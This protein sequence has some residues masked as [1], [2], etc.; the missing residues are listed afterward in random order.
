MKLLNFAIA[1]I[2]DANTGNGINRQFVNQ[3]GSNK[4]DYVRHGREIRANS[5]LALFG[6]IKTSIKQYIEDSKAA[7]QAREN[8]REILQMN[9]HLMKD[10][11]LNYNDG[12]DLRLGLISLDSLNARRDQNRNQQ[13]A[14]L[15]RLSQQ[16]VSVGKYDLESSNEEAYELAKCA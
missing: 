13:D 8:T 5:V 9:E 2:V 12:V 16:Q 3:F 11:G 14:G 4:T 7:A 10:I 15:A 6:K 1:S